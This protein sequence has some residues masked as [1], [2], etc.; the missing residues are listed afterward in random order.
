MF[1]KITTQEITK[2]LRHVRISSGASGNGAIS[3]CIGIGGWGDDVGVLW[4]AAGN[5]DVSLNG[6]RRLQRSRTAT[7]AILGRAVEERIESEGTG[8]EIHE[9]KFVGSQGDEKHVTKGK[10]QGMELG[11]SGSTDVK[12]V[13]EN[14]YHQHEQPKEENR[15]GIE[16]KAYDIHNG[17]IQSEKNENPV[18]FRLA[19]ESVVLSSVETE[20]ILPDD[21]DVIGKLNP[22][23]REAMERHAEMER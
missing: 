11:S 10:G 19:E 1:R 22:S 13:A 20:L 7:S 9:A 16:E 12:V 17:T 23:L 15:Y 5:V 8:G 18:D 2:V 14:D 4:K 3:D 6:F 21:M